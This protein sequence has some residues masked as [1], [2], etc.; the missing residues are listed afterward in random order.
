[1]LKQGGPLSNDDDN[2]HSDN[3]HV[4]ASAAGQVAENLRWFD[5]LRR[6]GPSALAAERVLGFVRQRDG[7]LTHGERQ[8]D[9]TDSDSGGREGGL[10]SL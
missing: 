9:W 1:M 10:T 7:G 5:S 2:R 4:A 3:V 8:R 6:T